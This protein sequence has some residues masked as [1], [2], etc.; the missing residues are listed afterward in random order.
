[1]WLPAVFGEITS[2]CGDLLVRQAA[3]E[4]PQ[5]LDLARGQPG[6]ALAAARDAVA[7]GAEH[8]LDRVGV[9]AARRATSARSSRRRLVGAAAPG[10]C[11][12]GSR[13]AW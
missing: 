5:H 13:I 12:R 2:R 7:G 4:Q 1:M 10:R 11:G 3:R 6:G 8:R 9:E